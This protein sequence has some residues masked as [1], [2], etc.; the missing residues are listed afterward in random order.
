MHI[1]TCK[2][3]T[4]GAEPLTSA[5]KWGGGGLCHSW[6]NRSLVVKLWLLSSI[7]QEN[8]SPQGDAYCFDGHDEVQSFIPRILPKESKSLLIEHKA[9][10]CHL[11]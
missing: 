4:P 9:D 10:A 5:I 2:H 6:G 8:R 7:N 3:V 11:K 1:R